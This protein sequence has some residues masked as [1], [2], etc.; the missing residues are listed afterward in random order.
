MSFMLNSNSEFIIRHADLIRNESQSFSQTTILYIDC[1]S[2]TNKYSI[3]MCEITH[4]Y[5]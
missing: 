2:L 4:V 3:Y 1:V 5:G